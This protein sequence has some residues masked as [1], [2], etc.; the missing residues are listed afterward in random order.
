MIHLIAGVVRETV[1]WSHIPWYWTT[2]CGI[3]KGAGWQ[4]WP[5]F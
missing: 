4:C 2:L 1:P 5:G 3:L